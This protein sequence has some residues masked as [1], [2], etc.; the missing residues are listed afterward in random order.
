MLFA[1]FSGWF[2]IS[3][4]IGFIAKSVG[5]NYWSYFFLSVFL[6]PIIGLVILMIKGK[7]TQD[8]L[9][10]S[11]PH[12]YFCTLCNS[13]YG[14]ASEKHATCPECG[15]I[16]TET[17]VLRSD[18]RTYSD[19]KKEELKNSFKHGQFLRDNFKNIPIAI[20]KDSATEIKQYKELLDV[21]AITQEEYDA[22]K[23][24]LLG[25]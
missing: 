13:T 17:S 14:G 3:L 22:K 16:L 1:V 10:D 18:W 25:L 19:Q 7:L 9:L 23:K 21:G 5:R 11:T 8:E 20:N 6:S 2:V 4:V 24:Q 15:N 12:I